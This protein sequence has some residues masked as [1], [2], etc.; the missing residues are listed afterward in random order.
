MER[1][2]VPVSEDRYT[3]QLSCEKI[4][5]EASQGSPKVSPSPEGRRAEPLRTRQSAAA[6]LKLVIA[7]CWEEGK[8]Q[9]A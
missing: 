2:Q 8:T 9:A 3:S 5:R 7:V 6:L 1:M 4:N